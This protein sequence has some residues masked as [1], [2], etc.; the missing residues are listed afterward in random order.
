[1]KGFLYKLT[2]LLSVIVTCLSVGV[3]VAHLVGLVEIAVDDNVSQIHV[4]TED[5]DGYQVEI[6]FHTNLNVIYQDIGFN[7][8][9]IA[10]IIG[11][12]VVGIKLLRAEELEEQKKEE[13]VPDNY[14]KLDDH[15]AHKP[16][17][18]SV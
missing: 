2:Y 16:I 8:L 9:M 15:N 5:K 18:E 10:G 11:L 3:I 6:I 1:M 4:F 17:L 14:V 13:S 7:L 12:C